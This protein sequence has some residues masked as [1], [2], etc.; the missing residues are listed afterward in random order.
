MYKIGCFLKSQ[1]KRSPSELD[2][3][4]FRLWCAWEDAFPGKSFNKYHGLFCAVRRYVHEYEMSGR[5][6][7]ESNEAFNATLEEIKK[8]LRSMVSHRQRINKIDERSQGNIK[9]GVL[10]KR[11]MIEEAKKGTKRG[12]Y[13][14][15]VKSAGNE[16]VLSE[17]RSCREIDGERVV[18]LGSGNLLYEEWVD[19]FDWFL[20]GVAPEDWLVRFRNTAPSD[21]GEI[22]NVVE[23]SSNL[24]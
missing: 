19:I 14:K 5:V 12:P 21:F 9:G 22:D 18:V 1:E 15:R 24:L 7:E 4:L 16:E 23:M 2:K 6:S 8:V 10:E 17:I 11:L 3:L 13:K 20:G